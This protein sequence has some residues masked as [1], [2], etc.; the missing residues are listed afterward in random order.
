ML[1][2]HLY[3]ELGIILKFNYGRVRLTVGVRGRVIYRATSGLRLGYKFELG[4]RL[5]L[6]LGLGF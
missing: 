3:I 6:R 2:L 5:E 1:G 4:L